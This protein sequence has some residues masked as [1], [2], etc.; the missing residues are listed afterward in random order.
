MTKK[1]AIAE[2]RELYVDLIPRGDAVMR[3]EEWCNYTDYLY[4]CGYIS[5]HQDRT[6][7]NPF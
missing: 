7:T 4:K 3:R 5:S 2:F 6:W 1:E